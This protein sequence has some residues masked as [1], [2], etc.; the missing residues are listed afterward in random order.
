MVT[1]CVVPLG[2]WGGYFSDN[3][4]SVKRNALGSA[5]EYNSQNALNLRL[6][7]AFVRSMNFD[8]DL[9]MSRFYAL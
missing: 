2:P 5:K 4:Q 9:F 8:L 3:R 6:R 7:H 1:C